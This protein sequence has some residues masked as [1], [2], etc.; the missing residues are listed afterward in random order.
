MCVCVL[1]TSTI[2]LNDG[3]GFP[4]SRNLLC[5]SV[6]VTGIER[7][8]ACNKAGPRCQSN[9]PKSMKTKSNSNLSNNGGMEMMCDDLW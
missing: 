6:F 9:K 8:P 3:M 4:L 1:Y 7:P 2:L 5:F